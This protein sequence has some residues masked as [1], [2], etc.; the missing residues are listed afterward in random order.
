M[1]EEPLD[2]PFALP[3]TNRRYLDAVLDH[4]VLFDGAMGTE[5]QKYPLT[6]EDFGGEATDGLME[7]L[8][9]HRPEW[10]A[11]VH[12]SYL[13]AG[14]EVIETD[15]F[16]ANRITFADFGLEERVVEINRR[17][18]RLAREVADEIAEV[19]G[20]P[21]FV[22][23]SMGP[24]G[25][26]PSLDDPQLS[27]I[28]FGELVGVF[29][30]Q[31]QGLIEGGVDLL[32]LETQQ[33]LLELK[34]AVLGIWESFRRLGVRLPIQAQITLDGGG[35]MLT[36]PDIDVAVVT[37]AALPVDLIGLNCSTGPDEMRP[38][39]RRLVS[40]SN[41]PAS[42]LPNAG[43]PRNVGGRAVYDLGAEPFA[44]AMVEFA[45]WGVRVVG[46]CCGTNPRH[47]QRLGE[48][49]AESGLRPLDGAGHP[50][51]TP[52]PADYRMEALPFAASNMRVV[53]L[54]QEPPPLLIGERLNTQGSRKARRLVLSRDYEAL[55]DLAEQQMAYGAHLLDLCVALTE[56]SDEPETMRHLTKLLALN[57]AAPLMFD[58]TDTEAME[59]A[60]TTYP[61][62][63]VV[64]SVH[65]EGGE[66]RARHI[67]RMVRRYG[68]A[69]VAL[70]IDESG[71]ARTVER[72]VAVARRL[73]RIAV[74]EIG[75]PPHALIFDALTFTLSTGDEALADSAK[76]TLEGIRRI[77]AELPGVFTNLGVSNVS[78]GFSPPARRVLNSV[79]LYH[80][81]Q[82]GL[83]MAIVNP[84]Q[85]TPYA[86]IPLRERELA[87]ALI[88]NRHAEA[89][90]DFIRYFEGAETA[91]VEQQ[92]EAVGTPSE[93]LY[94]AILHR[95]RQGVEV[96]VDE[97]VAERGA[98]AVL[99][100]VLLPAMKEVGDRFGAGELILPFVLKSAEVMK[101]AVARLERYLE[102]DETM[103]KGVVVLATVFGDVHDIGKN[104]VKTIFANNGYTVV[105][106]G[107]QVP[108]ST[109][110]E[111]VSEHGADA[112]GLSALLVS[113]SRQMQVVVDELRRRGMAVPVLIGGAAINSAFAER[114]AHDEEGE[115]Y[116][117]GVF[118]CKD[119]FEG[120]RVLDAL[121][122]GRAQPASISRQVRKPVAKAVGTAEERCPTCRVEVPTVRPVPPDARPHP[123]AWG[124][125][126][127]DPIPLDALWPLLD[128]RSLYRVGWGARGAR[129]ERWEAIVADFDA[130]LARM[131]REAATY[132]TPRGLYGY[133]P[134]QSEG[135]DLIVYDPVDPS[136]RREMARFTF[137]RQSKGRRLC[138]ADYFAPVGESQVDVV[139]FQ[140]VTAGDGATA[141]FAE[142][143]A[144]GAYSEA[145]FV[146]GLAAA[147]AE[148]AAEWLHAH[149]RRELGL[150]P[151]QGKRYSW[152]YPA[153]PDLEGH[154][155]LFRLLPVE[156]ELGVHLS[157]AA[158]LVPEYSTAALVVHH[159][160][161]T[162]FVV[163]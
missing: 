80:A 150:A 23:G 44:E 41:R 74:E 10:V 147:V 89:L 26:L 3:W 39:V 117:G 34:A 8:A 159:P 114:I 7:M 161:A 33:D 24:S 94:R 53:A 36:G 6:A 21:R 112:L 154:R 140:V 57:A 122:E 32:L 63:P 54:H 110:V 125:W 55:L 61:G 16:R 29:A 38:S 123:P 126:L 108:A 35:H 107:K 51:S 86:E 103:T 75:L 160:Q 151:D 2:I 13:E 143:E 115:P 11:A 45:R 152:G 132:L 4:I 138:L 48:R 106:L 99:N 37:L 162:Y 79:F 72:K 64:N 141:R 67:L 30:E 155:V 78:Y 95:R 76:A 19:T 87:E 65:L 52:P 146:H 133:F 109:I 131:W 58:T 73:Y 158:Q 128:R 130:R 18:A 92:R 83:D 81:V 156:A 77:K 68:A 47:I 69:I 124:Y 9:L 66:A 70:T 121:A 129:G 15:T 101:A 153:C 5:L 134:V 139:A 145:Y 135:N 144:S 98:L 105:D 111:A 113:T 20:V 40:L 22:A 85:I 25:K 100:E 116:A 157:P 49:L 136:A 31:A 82:A 62:R 14:A 96:L 27:D 28:T 137:P 84:A 90:S 149:I 93:Q 148:A 163:R 43:M 17:A 12:R 119:A 50:L 88:F 97:A 46:G 1:T 142:L 91:Q 56:R 59:A 120:L 104:L 71:M 118:Y 102:R 42:V 60:L 127:V